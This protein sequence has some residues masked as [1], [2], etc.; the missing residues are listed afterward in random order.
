MHDDEG[1]A[2]D[3]ASFKE[4]AAATA[5]FRPGAVDPGNLQG[6][7]RT[8][9]VRT[10]LVARVEENSKGSIRAIYSSH[11]DKVPM[12]LI[13]SSHS[14]FNLCDPG[15]WVQMGKYAK[16]AGWEWNT[17]L[18]R[19]AYPATFQR[20]QQTAQQVRESCRKLQENYFKQ[21]ITGDLDEIFVGIFRCTADTIWYSDTSIVIKK[22]SAMS[23]ALTTVADLTHQHRHKLHTL[24]FD[25]WLAQ[26][27]NAARDAVVVVNKVKVKVEYRLSASDQQLCYVNSKRIAH[28]DV[29]KVISQVTCFS[30]DQKGYD[31]YV[32]TVSAVSLKFHNFVAKG[33]PFKTLAIRKVG[34]AVAQKTLCDREMP[35][36]NNLVGEIKVAID[37]RFPVRKKPQ[38]RSEVF[39]C[40][41]W[42]KISNIDMLSRR[43]A[44]QR[45][46]GGKRYA[47]MDCSAAAVDSTERQVLEHLELLDNWIEKEDRIIP[48]SWISEYRRY[49]NDTQRAY[50][51]GD[52]TAEAKALVKQFNVAIQTSFNEQY[53]ALQKSREILAR[54]VEQEHVVVK[55]SGG[56]LVYEVT[57]KSGMVYLITESTGAVQVKQTKEHLCVVNGQNTEMAGYDYIAALISALRHD[58][59]TAKKIHTVDRALTRHQKA[60]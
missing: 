47:L 58:T 31:E 48:R 5:A 8:G 3:L 55:P 42:R 32:K 30:E 7:Y 4:V 57:G 15:A 38:T 12:A 21:F 29:N 54:I 1:E 52:K 16:N 26:I 14:A 45:Y 41:K 44:E 10:M 39:I 20:M 36:R 13:D 28:D 23:A 34:E 6:D 56:T 19:K 9:V 51:K 24:N 33:M 18:T 60:S 59:M 17:H 40:G 43:A 49:Y 25:T 37:A 27:V 50:L 2:E 46:R 35:A 22:K 53:K 11:D